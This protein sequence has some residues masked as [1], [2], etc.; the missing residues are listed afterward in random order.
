MALLLACHVR[1]AAQEI[2]YYIPNP[3]QIPALYG[4][5]DG[6][7]LAGLSMAASNPGYTIM[8]IYSPKKHW[9]AMI[10]HNGR[11]VNNFKNGTNFSITEIGAGGYY[12]ENNR[13][14]SG[15]L[16]YGQEKVSSVYDNNLSRT[17][18]L[19]LQ[20]Y[21]LQGAYAWTGNR[22]MAGVGMR[23]ILL[24]YQKGLISND[25]GYDYLVA[26]NKIERK[27]PVMYHELAFQIGIV[28][29]A[30]FLMTLHINAFFP[31]LDDLQIQQS[32]VG[33][34]LGYHIGRTK[35]DGT[36]P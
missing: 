12:M 13:C 32:S 19:W 8:G 3:V 15:M 14:A 21:F 27:S 31:E 20:R 36:N 11:K 2:T 28:R 5:G 34:C 16:G 30:P 33:L 9:M 25:I 26:L 35:A 29:Y 1:A 24:N 7:I 23:L 18:T 22:I 4:K 10:N 17:S 6:N